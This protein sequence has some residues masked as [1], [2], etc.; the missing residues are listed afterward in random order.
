MSEPTLADI[1]NAARRIAGRVRRTPMIRAIPLREHAGRAAGLW[2][3]AESLQVT[4][5]FKPRGA[6]NALSSLPPEQVARGIVTASGGNHSLGVAYAGWAAQVPA[7]VFLPQRVA[8]EKL[9][10]LAFWGAR[11]VVAGDAWDDS[12]QAALAHA[13]AEG[14]AYIHP[15]ADPLVIAGQGT[16]GLELLEDAPDLDTI[17]VAIGG[18]GLISGVALAAKAL[19]PGIRII[20]IEPT[21]A[22]TL[23]RSLEAGRL[24]TL[25]RLDTEA[26]TLAPRRSDE[27]NLAL[28][29]R[30]VDQIVLVSDAQMRQA[31]R[32][33]WR[34]LGVGAELS[35]AAAVAAVLGGHYH[36]GANERV[37]AVVCGAGTAG[38]G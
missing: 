2:L 16:L 18:G 10:A 6:V 29:A 12:H 14:L 38:F 8:A 26:V 21:G 17:L 5:S 23:A 19:K 13:E 27:I 22:P 9:A 36:P 11:V 20:G 37:C 35:G 28:I 25:D 33:L 32:W 30:L 24:V 1:R 3:K 34:E 15:F 7:T 4:G 31:A